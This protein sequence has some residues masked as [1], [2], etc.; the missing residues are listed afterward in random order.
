MKLRVIGLAFALAVLA[1][2]TGFALRELSAQAPAA[3]S[4]RELGTVPARF[5]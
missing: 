1:S 3:R 4:A 5:R 2:P